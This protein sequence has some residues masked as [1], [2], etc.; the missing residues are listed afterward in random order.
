MSN[1]RKVEVDADALYQVLQALIGPGHL[2]RELQVMRAFK[3]NPID[4]LVTQYNQ[5]VQEPGDAASNPG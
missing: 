5:Q 3:D 4:L 1:G 2:I